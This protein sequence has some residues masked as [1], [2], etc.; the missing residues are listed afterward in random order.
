[1][2]PVSNWHLL[3]L[4]CTFFNNSRAYV[5]HKIYYSQALKLRAVVHLVDETAG[6]SETTWKT[7]K[8]GRKYQ[9]WT[10]VA[11]PSHSAFPWSTSETLSFKMASGYPQCVPLL[12]LISGE[13]EADLLTPHSWVD[14]Q[15]QLWDSAP[16]IL[17]WRAWQAT[18]I[19][20]SR[21]GRVQH[22]HPG[23]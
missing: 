9:L 17:H 12:L 18:E 16:W 15:R 2:R 20:S 19:M 5:Q 11:P 3:C 6:L 8:T 21:P 7:Q 14:Q 1:M 4:Y 23:I 10:G 13:E 22:Y